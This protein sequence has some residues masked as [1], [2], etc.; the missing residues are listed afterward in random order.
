[1]RDVEITQ[2]Q[3]VCFFAVAS[4]LQ[5][6]FALVFLDG[7]GNLT[8]TRSRFKCFELCVGKLATCPDLDMKVLWL[9]C[10]S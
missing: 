1:M 9:V 10:F 5:E 8:L 7:R 6:E 2:F 3:S 4:A